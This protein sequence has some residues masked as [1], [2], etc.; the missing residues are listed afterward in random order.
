MSNASHGSCRERET[1]LER[2]RNNKEQIHAFYESI[3]DD[4]SLTTHAEFYLQ[5]YLA[6]ARD[7]DRY[8]QDG[9]L[10]ETTAGIPDK[11]VAATD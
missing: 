4:S 6:A 7:F 2:L 10:P 9:D 3:K 8:V 1:N 11:S 5:L